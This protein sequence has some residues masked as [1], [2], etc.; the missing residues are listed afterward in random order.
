MLDTGNTYSYNK[1]LMGQYNGLD[2]D[3]KEIIDH[4]RTP[5][6][7]GFKIEL[8]N[9]TFIWCSNYKLADQQDLVCA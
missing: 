1:S 5:G 7:S 3:Q 2:D 6:K 4:Y 8:T 9:I